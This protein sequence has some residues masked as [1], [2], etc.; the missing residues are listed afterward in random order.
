MLLCPIYFVMRAVRVE[1]F[2]FFVFFVSFV[3]NEKCQ[4]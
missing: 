2:V 1:I 3:V 4:N